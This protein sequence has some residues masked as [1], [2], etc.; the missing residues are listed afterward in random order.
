M[1]KIG[2]FRKKK[3]NILDL[4]YCHGQDVPLLIVNRIGA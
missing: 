4:E 3:L 2:Y 1:N